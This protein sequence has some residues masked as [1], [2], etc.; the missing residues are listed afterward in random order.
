MWFLTQHRRWGLLKRDVDYLAIARQV[1]R[2]D[3]YRAAAA[4]AKA[5]L[6]DSDMR[7]SRLMDGSVWDGREPA[8][9]AAAHPIHA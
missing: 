7:A 1:N 3:I 5:P 2:I 9:F 6:P 8:R 4:A